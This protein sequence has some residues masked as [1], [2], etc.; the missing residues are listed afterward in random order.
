VSNQGGEA[1]IHPT[2]H[3]VGLIET[4]L[5]LEKASRKD[6]FIPF[7]EKKSVT[8]NPCKEVGNHPQDVNS[9][10]IARNDFTEHQSGAKGFE[11]SKKDRSRG[12]SSNFRQI[13][14]KT[15][16][17]MEELLMVKENPPLFEVNSPLISKFW[18]GISIVFA[19]LEG[20]IGNGF[21]K[22]AEPQVKSLLTAYF[23]AKISGVK[24]TPE[25]LHRYNNIRLR[26]RK[27]S[28]ILWGANSQVLH[29]LEKMKL[30]INHLEEQK[31]IQVWFS[32]L[33]R[34]CRG[35]RPIFQAKKTHNHQ[36][37]EIDEG[38]IYQK[39]IKSVHA[40]SDITA[41]QVYQHG[42]TK[43]PILVSNSQILMNEAVVHFLVFYHKIIKNRWDGV[44]SS[45]TDFI[46]QL[47]NFEDMIQHKSLQELQKSKDEYSR[48]E[49]Q[50][51]RSYEKFSLA[52]FLNSKPTLS[53]LH[54]EIHLKP[55]FPEKKIN[56]MQFFDI[57]IDFKSKNS[58]DELWAWISRVKLSPKKNFNKYFQPL[59]LTIVN[60]V[61]DYLINF[62]MT[63]LSEEMKSKIQET[64]EKKITKL[65]DQ[66][67]DIIWVLNDQILESFAC[68]IL[69]EDYIY[70]QKS[71]QMFFLSCFS[72]VNGKKSRNSQE[73]DNEKSMINE[74]IIHLFID[75]LTLDE[76]I[77]RFN[78]SPTALNHD[79]MII[80]S[81]DLII[82]RICTHILGYY[83]KS[84]NPQKYMDLFQKDKWFFQYILNMSTTCFSRK[85]NRIPDHFKI[86]Q[87]NRIIPWKRELDIKLTSQMHYKLGSDIKTSK[88]SIKRLVKPVN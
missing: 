2:D 25:Q 8:S 56:E 55:I 63:Y 86:F 59:S 62:S 40:T 64:S 71:I 54:F 3:F 66:I 1:H 18:A 30:R 50:F 69:G 4:N 57:K 14:T 85:F 7:H 60:E 44:F 38:N 13:Q 58:T 75:A 15:G 6:V 61:K 80:H 52:G 17:N 5:E 35:N 12:S 46:Y 84:Q 72:E 74:R 70:E 39:I 27:L 42:L 33:L 43:E 21:E 77:K 16:K 22:N 47:T 87:K 51:L 88:Q 37:L 19:H 26:F 53:E 76:N 24:K 68:Q 82:G 11:K 83:Y 29:I 41:F 67:F 81:E 34:R 20:S 9:D 48:I 65:M 45:D 23:S 78:V 36:W 73:N 32:N 79:K 49:H 10:Q 31:E 28:Q